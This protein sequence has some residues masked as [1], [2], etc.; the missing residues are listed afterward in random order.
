MTTTASTKYAALKSEPANRDDPV[1][2]ARVVELADDRQRDTA[3]HGADA[4]QF[5]QQR[6]TATTCR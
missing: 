3:D 1:G 6:A 5:D 4:E 2:P